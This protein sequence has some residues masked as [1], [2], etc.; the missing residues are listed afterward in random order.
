MTPW[1]PKSTTRQAQRSERKGAKQ[2]G[3]T[4]TPMSGAGRQ[5]GDYKNANWLTEDKDT[6]ARSFRVE[7]DEHLLKIEREAAQQRPH[8][9]PKMRITI[10][11]Y[12]VWVIRESDALALGL[13]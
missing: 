5:K 1:K 4:T 11:G 9:M 7:L 12:T 13:A 8:R 2:E 3:G 10:S 6:A